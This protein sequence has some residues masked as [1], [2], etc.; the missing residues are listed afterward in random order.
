MA[1]E[2]NISLAQ[3]DIDAEFGNL[4]AQATDTA[5]VE[6]KL[7]ELYNWTSS[8]F[9]EK[10][11]VPYLL[12]SKLQGSLATD[13]TVNADA[14]KTADE[15][16]TA[17]QKGE[18]TFE[19]LAKQYSQD[20]SAASGGDLG[21][22][23]RGQMVQEFEDAAFALEVGQ[24]SGLVKTQFG[25]HIIKLLEKVAASGETPEQLRAEQILIKI[26]D[27]DEWTNEELAKKKIRLLVGNYDWKK[28]C[29]LVLR[30][31]ETCDDNDLVGATSID[32]ADNSANEN[33]NIA[34]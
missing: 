26:K 9:K 27:I 10:V 7:K 22:F 12:R 23:S 13:E 33:A 6:A 17:V 3:A 28:D 15:V 19:D 20:A 29:G 30:Q 11:I 2:K 8:E 25:Y 34:Q 16:L 31:D 5:E 14:K 1:A 18:I 32:T 24:V 4:V 21:Y